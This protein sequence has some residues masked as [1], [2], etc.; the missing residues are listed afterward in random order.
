MKLDI[1]LFPVSMV[2]IEHKKILV[3]TDQ[4]ETTK[5]N[6]VISNDLCNR[7]IKPHNL[8]IGTWKENV[9]RKLAKRVKPMSAML[10][11]K[12]SAAVGG[13]SEVPGRP[14]DQTG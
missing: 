13:R 2:E 4:A 1:D 14:R 10:I 8:E 7:M 11:E 3:R 9:Q 6:V 12:I 5:G